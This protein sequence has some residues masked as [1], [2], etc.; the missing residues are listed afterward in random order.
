M[1]IGSRERRERTGR[2]F[3][4]AV[5]TYNYFEMLD[6]RPGR[7]PNLGKLDDGR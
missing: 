7:C 3:D 4:P 2:L 1:D 5:V 6:L